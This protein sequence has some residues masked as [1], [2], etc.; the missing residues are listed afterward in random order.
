MRCWYL[1]TMARSWHLADTKVHVYERGWLRSFLDALT[2]NR[3]WLQTCRLKD[4]VEDQPPRGK[5]Y[6]P[7]CSYR[8]MTEWALPVPQQD[9]Y[10]DVMHVLHEHP[11]WADMQRFVRGGNWRNFKVRYTEA[12]E[13]YSRMM[14]VSRR[15]EQANSS[16]PTHKFSPKSKISSTAVNAIAPTGTVA[17]GGIYLPHLRNAIY[18]ELIQADTQLDRLQ[19]GDGSWVEAT[20]EDYDFDLRPEVRLANDQMIAF[21]APA[22]GGMLYELDIRDV[23]H[24]ILAT[25]QRR[26]ESYH[27]NVLRGA[28]GADQSVA[29]IHDRIVFKQE[30][31]D[32][33]LQ[34]DRFP[35]KSFLEHF[36]DNDVTLDRVAEDWPKNVVTL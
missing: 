23:S 3:D 30:G 22:Q 34:Y 21:V 25:L 10:E 8:E 6:L 33:R 31:L 27:R 14:L 13:M 11:R 18:R 2:A 36:Y 20:T 19:H 12:N 16:V 5:I 32:K 35:R 1:V 26:P 15:L 7:D 9:L 29:S 4:V 24:N 17:F 28:S